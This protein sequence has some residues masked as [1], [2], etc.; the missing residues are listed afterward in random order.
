MN[1]LRKLTNLF[2]GGGG[3]SVMWLYARCDACGEVVA[4]RINLFNDL[5]ATYGDEGEGAFVWRKQ[6]VGQR[7]MCYRPMD[8]ELRFDAQRRE[9]S[10]QIRGG[11]FVNERDY[12]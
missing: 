10:R 5:S 6:L 4:S 12:L 3:G 7:R 11:T 9:L 2:S 8:V 1:L